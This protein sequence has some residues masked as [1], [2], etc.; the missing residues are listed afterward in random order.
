MEVLLGF[1][2]NIAAQLLSLT[3]LNRTEPETPAISILS[4]TQLSVLVAHCPSSVPPML[5][6]AWA[7]KEIA[8]LGGYLEHRKNSAIGITVLWRGWSQLQQLCL[9]WTLHARH[10]RTT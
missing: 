9:G 6:V 3:Y 4:E 5:T 8:R 2:T 10:S 1:L 7:T